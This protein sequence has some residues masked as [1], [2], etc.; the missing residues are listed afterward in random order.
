MIFLGAC[1]I[2]AYGPLDW[3][4]PWWVWAFTLTEA[5]AGGINWYSADERMERIARALSRIP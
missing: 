2:L 3:E 1:L 5:V 4:F